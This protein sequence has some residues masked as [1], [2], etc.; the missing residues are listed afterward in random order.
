[1]KMKK[2]I[3]KDGT[4]DSKL[5]A[6][7]KHCNELKEE[8]FSYQ[9]M[10]SSL[11]P[12]LIMFDIESGTIIQESISQSGLGKTHFPNWNCL[13]GKNIMTLLEGQSSDKIEH[14]KR[15]LKMLN[16]PFCQQS[17]SKHEFTDLAPVF[18]INSE[19]GKQAELVL[20]LPLQTN[21][22]HHE[23]CGILT[24]LKEQE[25]STNSISIIREFMEEVNRVIKKYPEE[26][27]G[28][29]N[30]IE[31]DLNNV[32]T[33][34]S[35]F[36]EDSKTFIEIFR[37]IH[38]VKGLAQSFDLRLIAGAAHRL[39][40]AMQTSAEDKTGTQDDSN[41]KEHYQ[42][43]YALITLAKT[44][45]LTD[46]QGGVSNRKTG[47]D[48]IAMDGIE[49]RLE[50]IVRNSREKT[51]KV[52]QFTIRN[53]LNLSLNTT[54]AYSLGVCLTQLLKNAIFHGIKTD[55]GR[56]SELAEIVLQTEKWGEYLL[57]C[58]ADNGQGISLQNVLNH[59]VK[60][61]LLNQKK[62][63]EILRNQNKDTL[64]QVLSIP[65]FSTAESVSMFS[66]RGFGLDVVKAEVETI[67]GELILESMKGDGAK[68]C[69]K[70]PLET[71]K[72]TI[73]E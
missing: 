7:H 63:D 47:F 55:S 38:S 1:M 65:G 53:R 36:E 59:A 46:T 21:N 9:S 42:N 22:P 72:I 62:A 61:N 48:H 73:H 24:L 37:V 26:L 35:Y 3:F 58:I 27:P 51:G 67:G 18:V 8:L 57:I 28:I 29:L 71:N 25:K 54:V 45:L 14:M 34:L 20:S 17:M 33:G 30:E 10:L 69:L 60:I 39:E 70:I 49:K 16:D 44:L 11:D 41:I 4:S 32:E 64:L 56:E 66:G 50:T 23:V 13:K 2:R 15:W 6:L 68:F 12:L 5:K 43:L 40:S 31:I 52:F 19:L